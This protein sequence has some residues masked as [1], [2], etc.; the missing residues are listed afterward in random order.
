MN[1]YVV[2]E[3]IL[4]KGNKPE[5]DIIQ[6]IFKCCVSKMYL[7]VLLPNIKH[8]YDQIDQIDQIE[9]LIRALYCELVL[10]LR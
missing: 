5:Y 1:I 7:I 3:I 6:I 2:M 10:F 4:K 9:K 8:M